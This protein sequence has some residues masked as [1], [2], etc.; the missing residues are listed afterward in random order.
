MK[1]TIL[2]IFTC[3]VAISIFNSCTKDGDLSYLKKGD[4]QTTGTNLNTIQVDSFTVT[5]AQWMLSTPVWIAHDT[6]AATMDLSGGVFLF[7][8]DGNDWSAIPHVDYGVQTTFGFEAISKSIEIHSYSAIDTATVIANPGTVTFKVV[9]MPLRMCRT[10]P[11]TDFKNYKSIKATFN[12]K[13]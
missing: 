8:K 5:A 2:F 12:L 9:T 1:K 13:D 10:N 3:I 11:S 6:L 7:S 4:Y